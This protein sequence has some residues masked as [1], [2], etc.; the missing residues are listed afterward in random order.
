MS[1]HQQDET[2]ATKQRRAPT[3]DLVAGD[4]A[5]GSTAVKLPEGQEHGANPFDILSDAEPL[6]EAHHLL[7][8]DCVDRGSIQ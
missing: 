1:L 3:K 8:S 2:R 7:V 5:V 4:G 6:V